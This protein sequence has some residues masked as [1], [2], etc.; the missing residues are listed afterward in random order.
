MRIDENNN[1]VEITS[2]SYDDSET[3]YIEKNLY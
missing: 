3:N 1:D 2:E